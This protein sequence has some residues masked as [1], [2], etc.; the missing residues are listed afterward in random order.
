MKRVR[1]AGENAFWTSS[2]RPSEL[3]REA[4]LKTTYQD[5]QRHRHG[6][7]EWVSI[8]EREIGDVLDLLKRN[9]SMTTGE[10]LGVL[11]ADTGNTGNVD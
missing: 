6:L 3:S 2:E 4:L 7:G 11:R 8:K 10:A 1:E 9:E 5:Y